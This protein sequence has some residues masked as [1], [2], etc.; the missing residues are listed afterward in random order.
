MTIEHAS[1][2][3]K[4]CELSPIEL[5]DSCLKVIDERDHE[6][7][8]WVILD[9]EGALEQARTFEQQARDGNM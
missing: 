8:A 5:L 3:I 9:R 1:E 6:I 2:L 4:K 7:R